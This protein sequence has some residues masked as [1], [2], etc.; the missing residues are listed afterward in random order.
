LTTERAPVTLGTLSDQVALM[1]ARLCAQD[2][3]LASIRMENQISDISMGIG[4][5][6]LFENRLAALEEL[7]AG[8]HEPV[9]KAPSEQTISIQDTVVHLDARIGA[10]E[11][12]MPQCAEASRV[13]FQ[14]T[15]PR[16]ASAVDPTNRPLGGQTGRTAATHS[17]E[18]A[19]PPSTSSCRPLNVVTWRPAAAHTMSRCQP[20]LDSYFTAAM[21]ALRCYV[22]R[23]SLHPR[24]TPCGT[25]I[26]L[27]CY[28]HMVLFSKIAFVKVTVR[29]TVLVSQR[30]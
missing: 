19:Q 7:A 23:A 5:T 22:G 18:D 13:C 24:G 16:G 26:R 25:T 20:I 3:G 29:S 2:A 30:H 8:M 4:N 14:A 11:L 21:L 1:D 28:T 15:S 10:L 27:E 6:E 9:Q 12:Q 17:I